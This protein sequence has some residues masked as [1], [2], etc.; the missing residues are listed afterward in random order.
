MV[1]LQG[2]ADYFAVWPAV[3]DER[4]NS[5]DGFTGVMRFVR[6]RCHSY[7][8]DLP[9]VVIADFGNSDIELVL[10]PLKQ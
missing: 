2:S 5:V 6:H 1:N 9:G 10:D 3:F 4:N 8:R 7:R